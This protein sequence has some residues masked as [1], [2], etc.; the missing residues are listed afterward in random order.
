MVPTQ[1]LGPILALSAPQHIDRTRVSTERRYN[2]RAQFVSAVDFT[3][4]KI[5]YSSLVLIIVGGVGH[6]PWEPAGSLLAAFLGP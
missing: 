6:W 5:N 1:Q 3:V 4:G 2:N